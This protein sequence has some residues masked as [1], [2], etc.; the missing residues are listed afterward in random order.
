MCRFWPGMCYKNC[1]VPESLAWQ[2]IKTFYTLT[3]LPIWS[4]S[5]SLPSPPPPPHADACTHIQ[6]ILKDSLE[7]KC[8]W[9][10]LHLTL[11]RVLF[12]CYFKCLISI[13]R[14]IVNHWFGLF[15]QC[16]Y[17]TYAW[18]LRENYSGRWCG[19]GITH[20]S[21]MWW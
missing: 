16:V 3:F 19:W 4:L 12:Q 14:I 20:S 2:T 6:S 9:T 8:I 7:K 17:H 15:F 13:G 18:G 5:L 11:R 1:L 10:T 21:T